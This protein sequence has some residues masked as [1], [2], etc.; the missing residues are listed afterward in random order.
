MSEKQ[1]PEIELFYLNGCPYCRKA[2]SVIDALYAENPI[3][4]SIPIRWIEEREEKELADAR[5]Y[6]RV[7]TLFCRREKLYEASPTHSETEIRDHIRAAFDR[8]LNEN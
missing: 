6:F 2:K 5:D 3:Y 7:P 8:V 4:S 1:L